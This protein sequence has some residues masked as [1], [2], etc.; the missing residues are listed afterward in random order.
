[1]HNLIPKICKIAKLKDCPKAH[2]VV[3]LLDN[4]VDDIAFGA[5]VD[6]SSMRPCHDQDIGAY[7]EG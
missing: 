2:F 6:L 4:S 5:P 1:M 7:Q 3:L